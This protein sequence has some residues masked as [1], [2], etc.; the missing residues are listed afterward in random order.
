MPR[1]AK[2]GVC[3]RNR[4]TGFTLIELLVVIAIIAILASLLLPSLTRAKA[5]S[6]QVKCLNNQKQIG[7]AYHMYASD[8]LDWYPDVP[9][10]AIVGGIRGLRNFYDGDRYGW[11]ERPL[12]RYAESRLIWGCPNDKGDALVFSPYDHE[13]RRVETCYET[14][15]TSYLVQWGWSSWRVQQVAGN[16]SDPNNKPIQSSTIALAPVNKIIQGDWH[17]HGN[18]DKNDPRSVWHN[19]KGQARNNMLFGDGHVEFYA[20]PAEY[21]SWGTVPPDPS[22]TWW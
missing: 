6:Q 8:N 15:G 3:G 20:F 5:K 17:W 7:L 19:A 14:Y 21:P 12:N 16:S 4:D 22:F 13:G 2:R 10:W 9:N 18:R 11:D 1:A